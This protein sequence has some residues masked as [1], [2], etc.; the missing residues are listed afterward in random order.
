MTEMHSPGKNWRVILTL[1][2]SALGI[3]FF[4]VQA[5]ALAVFWLTSFLDPVISMPESVS[6]GLFFWTSILG[7]LMLI[8][9]LLLSIY[10]L[11]GKPVPGWLDLTRPSLSKA[12]RGVILVW[13]VLV[14]LG[15][16]ITSQEGLAVFLLGPINVLV[17]GLPILW[18]F[19]AA[20][21][22]LSGGSHM[23]KWRIFGFSI[24]LLPIL[25]I[26]VELLAVVLLGGMGLA[27]VGLRT[28]A[29]PQIERDIAYLTNQFMAYGD[30]FDA[31]IQFLKPYILQPPIIYWALAIFGGII[32]IIEEVIK[33]LALWTLAGRKITPQ[34][35]FVGGL[36]CGAGFA[37]M[38][39]VF[40]FTTVLLSEE[41]LFM[42]I[43][44]AGTGVLHMLASGLVGWGLAATWGKRKWALLVLTTLGAFVLHGVWNI[45]AVISGVV[46]LLILESEPTSLQLLVS[47]APVVLLLILSI[48]GLF[49][50]N[51]HLRAKARDVLLSSVE[52]QGEG[53]F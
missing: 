30:N 53:E 36:L 15:W 31:L 7:G 17:A 14:L 35:G 40:Y 4:I 23:R 43:G 50:I 24:T 41:W 28:A 39:N 48:F 9:V 5:L 22:G 13:P 2:I 1:V 45:L 37:L 38:E 42:A 47:H 18:I 20:Q 51:R 21:S 16:W 6:I 49:L 29:D 44:R 46:P 3:L 26:L 52:S 33:P 19:N 34:E 32:P 8:P 11:Q 27:Y 10:A 25:V 12:L